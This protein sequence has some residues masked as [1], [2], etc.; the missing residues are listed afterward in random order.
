MLDEVLDKIKDTEK[1]IID[2]DEKYAKEDNEK[3]A[4][5]LWHRKERAEVKLD[6]LIDEADKIREGTE[7]AENK[8]TKST[9]P[10]KVEKAAKVEK[11]E[12]VCL[13]CGSDLEDMGGLVYRC[14]NCGEYFEEVKE[15]EEE[16]EEK[17]EEDE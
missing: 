7:G 1:R 17:E 11:D 8:S 5:V 14:L 16:E 15:E 13:E 9:N 3:A 4:E 10:T 2:L 12:T 6:K